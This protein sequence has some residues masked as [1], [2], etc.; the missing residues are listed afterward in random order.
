MKAYGGEENASE[1]R[2][3]EEGVPRSVRDES[4]LEAI[5]A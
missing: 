3:L 1:S 5:F 4:P 2:H